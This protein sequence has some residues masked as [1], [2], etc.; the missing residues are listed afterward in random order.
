MMRLMA[1][2]SARR[3]IR[4]PMAAGTRYAA[5]LRPAA[6]RNAGCREFH[7]GMPLLI[8]AASAFKLLKLSA[9]WGSVFS[10]SSFGKYTLSG[11]PGSDS[12]AKI[13]GR[14]M[15]RSA[16]LSGATLVGGVI[17]VQQTSVEDV[18]VSGRRRL[19]LT[20]REEER[21]IGKESSE[22]LLRMYQQQGKVLLVQDI[23]ASDKPPKPPLSYHKMRRGMLWASA[24]S[25]EKVD[26][27]V[28]TP[29]GR[30]WWASTPQG[31][32]VISAAHRIVQAVRRSVDLPDGLEQL[33][34][35]L[36]VIN[37]RAVPNAMVL[38][39]GHIFVFTGILPFCPSEDTLGFLLGHEAA[40]ACL[41]HAGEK[42]S[43][44]PFFES[45]WLWL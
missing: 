26:A 24:Q 8:K 33:E 36:H 18:Q 41:R 4:S 6:F 11:A 2:A 7:P 16:I 5:T 38:P 22:Q 39:N 43:E 29:D 10:R 28:T 15:R 31:Q 45:A 32:T 3:L 44:Q 40:H 27:W 1:A 42:L 12:I 35:R 23:A 20:T 17:Y 13:W 34:W 19:L 25:P 21:E 9:S 37:D 30:K 14:W